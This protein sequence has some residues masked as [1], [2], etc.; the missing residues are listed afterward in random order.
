M[1]D[2]SSRPADVSVDAGT[3]Y[4]RR[5]DLRYSFV[6]KIELTD[7]SGK[8]IVA[9]TSNIS[10]YGC[11]VPTN[12][13]FLPGTSVKLRIKHERTTFESEGKVV[14]AVSG[15][16]MGIHFGNVP[17]GER[18][19]LREWLVQVS[20]AEL[21]HRLRQSREANAS[22]P[23]KIIVLSALIVVSVATLALTLL[24]FGLL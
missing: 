24:C 21:E 23:Q 12:A 16:G 14:Y 18:A 11:H 5:S 9:V 10:R 19:V 1:K 6:A 15:D 2:S 20:A 8:Q 13:P 4:P 22:T 7:S 3:V 17:A